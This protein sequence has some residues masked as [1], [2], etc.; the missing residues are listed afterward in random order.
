MNNKQRR[1]SELKH[2][3]YEQRRKSKGNKEYIYRKL[4][5]E[6]VEFVSNFCVVEP[7]LFEIRRTFRPGFNP[8]TAP[9]IVKSVFYAKRSPVYRVPS[10]KEVSQCKNAG[11]KVFPYKFK[12]HLNTLK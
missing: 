6:Q 1:L 7:H 11:L 5:Q 10:Q 8:N 2:E 3:L 12:I 4:T 9:G